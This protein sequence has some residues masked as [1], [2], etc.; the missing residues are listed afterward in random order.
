MI[1]K[2]KKY[3]HIPI[4]EKV[5]L[6]KWI[7]EQRERKKSMK[8]IGDSIGMSK[9]RVWQYDRFFIAIKEESE[10]WGKT[11]DLAIEDSKKA[12]EKLWSRTQK[13]NLIA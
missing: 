3:S 7:H 4:Y 13:Q 9:G 12:S 11:I 8:E 2:Y 10:S 1:P 6:A 5:R